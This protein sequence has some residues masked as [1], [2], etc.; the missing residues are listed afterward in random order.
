MNMLRHIALLLLM[1]CWAGPAQGQTTWHVD[2][3]CTPPGAGTEFDPFCTIQDAVDAT[4]DGDT[5]LVA[6]G[7]YTGDG[8]R[9]ISLF[10]RIITLR[11]TEGPEATTIDI[12]GNP[13][14]IH[15]GFFLIHGETTDTVIEGF[16]ITNAYLIG[17]TGG[18]GPGGGGGG[19]I[20][21]RDSSPTIRNCIIRENISATLS[22]PF[23]VDGRG[24]G[25]YIDGGSSALIE[26]CIVAD[27]MADR[28]GGGM[29]IGY[30]N[31]TVGVR[32]C[33]VSG[34]T[35]GVNYPGGGVYLTFGT[36]TISNTTIV[37]NTS[38][39]AGGGILAEGSEPLLT[40]CILWENQAGPKYPG[41][42]IAINGA[43]TVTISYS[44]VE[45]GL[46]GVEGPGQL[47]WGPGMIDSDP[48]FS[49][50]ENND[51]HLLH[52]SPCI[53]AGNNLAVPEGVVTDLD[54][55]PRFLDDPDTPDTGN[56]DPDDPK[57]PI[58][59]MGP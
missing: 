17:D 12:E 55:G 36:T 31:S 7:T 42:Q 32:N 16:T 22:P 46:G 40:N 37:K 35:N 48:L 59:D 51:Y 6:P 9:D 24:A 2:D 18:T 19:A 26:N 8:N 56:P 28:R 33:L 30:E 29:Y 5:V 47:N 21:I 1:A 10:G 13:Q 44:T 39:G 25:I 3:D 58:V 43:A 38:G 14:S 45:G 52:G 4:S 23:P 53:D 49:N 20:Y 15:R 54:G 41:Q 27:N 57:L 50:P 11:S 34:N